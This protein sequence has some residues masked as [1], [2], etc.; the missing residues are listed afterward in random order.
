MAK[1]L[2]PYELPLVEYDVSE[3]ETLLDVFYSLERLSGTFDD[4][5]LHIDKRLNDERNRL[6]KIHERVSTCQTKVSKV[7]GSKR[8]TTVFSTAKFPAPKS[9]PAYPTL[10]SQST[11]MPAPFRPVNDEVRYLPPN[12]RKSVIQDKELL[13]EVQLITGRLNSYGSDMEKVEFIMEDQSLGP[14]PPS[15]ASVGSMLLFNSSIN[16]YK[17]YQTLDNLLASTSRTKTSEKETGKQLASAPSTLLSGD[18]LPDIAALDLTFKPEMG[19]MTALAL[20]SN[21]PLDFLADIQYQGAALPSIAPSFYGK[22]DYS[23][24]QITDGG[25]GGA[26]PSA[27]QPNLPNTISQPQASKNTPPPPP[28]GQS[29]MPPPP[30]PPGNQSNMPPPPPPPGQNN[31][32]PPPPPM[33]NTAAPSAGDAKEVVEDDDDDDDDDDAGAAG[34]GGGMSSLLAAIKG[35]NVNKLRKRE[36][37][38]VA[39]AKKQREEVSKPISMMEEMRLRMQRR[40]DAIS[41]KKDKEDQRRDSLIVQNVRQSMADVVVQASTQN[42]PPPPPPIGAKP[43][44]LLSAGFAPVEDSDNDSDG[45]RMPRYTK[46]VSNDDDTVSSDASDVSDISFD[47]PAA[48]STQVKVES[49][50]KPVVVPPPVIAKPTVKEDPVVASTVPAARRGSLLDESNQTIKSMLTTVIAKNNNDSSDDDEEEWDD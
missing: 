18:A 28:P 23:L 6:A 48:V 2:Q 12:P 30:P 5:F 15:L 50:I 21:L 14:F 17:D 47:E 9:L 35:M 46:P 39:A 49:K 3:D 24:P 25:M 41:G 42:K 22:A 43:S 8:A 29:S 27:K 20:P 31:M 33:V 13:S 34:D 26:M 1:I 45:P 44:S 38:N 11:D 36:E 10:F 37:A 19:E 40:N 4:I 7:K 32:P 16:P